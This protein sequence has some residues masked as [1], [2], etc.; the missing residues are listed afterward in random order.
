MLWLSWVK[1]KGQGDLLLCVHGF[2][3]LRSA[4]TSSSNNLCTKFFRPVYQRMHDYC[5]I[6]YHTNWQLKEDNQSSYFTFSGGL[7]F[8]IVNIVGN[9]GTVFCDQAYWQSS[10]AAKPLQVETAQNVFRVWLVLTQSEV[11]TS[12]P[13]TW[14]PTL[15][16][17]F[18]PCCHFQMQIEPLL[19][20][21]FLSPVLQAICFPCN[22]SREPFL[23]SKAIST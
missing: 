17:H 3:S 16:L 14:Q 10:V 7:V 1:R 12:A 13:S 21:E 5:L 22:R 15:G 19:P 11:T 4:L 8:G 18:S 23:F 9:F 20:W 6:T 2:Y